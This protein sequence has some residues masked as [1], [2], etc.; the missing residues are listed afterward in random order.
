MGY[1]RTVSC[2]VLGIVLSTQRYQ[3]HHNLWFWA[4]K[5][6]LTTV[7][8][9][10][11]MIFRKTCEFHRFSMKTC[12]IHRFLRYSPISLTDSKTSISWRSIHPISTLF[13]IRV[14]QNYSCEKWELANKMFLGYPPCNH[15][16][17]QCNWLI[18]RRTLD[19][20]E[21]AELAGRRSWC[22][23]MQIPAWE[24]W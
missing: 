1:P 6:F 18:F 11:I 19:A 3:K 8:H 16:D 15:V 5:Y 21:A 12:E 13:G 7:K 23:K 20:V 14:D 9:Y 22:H 2:G 4:K 10:R 17:R 24:S